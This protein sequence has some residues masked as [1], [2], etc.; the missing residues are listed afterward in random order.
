MRLHAWK[1][2]T[3][4]YAGLLAL[5]LLIPAP[6]GSDL[7]ISEMCDPRYNYA[8]DRFIEIYN[9]G[10]NPV[11]L[12]GWSLQAV[13]NGGI[14]FIWQL[15]GT[16][17][18]GEAL[19]AGDQT[20]TVPFQVDFPDEAW[21]DSNGLWNGKVGDGAKLL[22]PGNVL[23]DCAV[24]EGTAFEN[25]DYVRRPNVT[26]PS[27]TY[28]AAEWISTS[29][30]YPTDGSPGSHVA[31]PPP[32]GPIIAAIFTEPLRPLSGQSVAVFAEVRDTTAA[33]ESVTLAWGTQPGSLPHVIAME[34]L[35]GDTYQTSYPIPGQAP[36]TS[37][38][39]QIEAINTLS[40]SRLSAVL[41]YAVP[42]EL[43]VREIQGE[44]EESPYDNET[45]VT[46]GLVT[47]SFG[48]HFVIQDGTGPW[49]GL[50]VQSSAL[51]GRG[52][53]VTVWGIVDEDS[54]NT[55]L[56][57]A[58]IEESAPGGPLPSP[59]DLTTGAAAT[60][61]YEGVLVKVSDARCMSID[62]ASGVW[63]LYDGSGPLRVGVLG[64]DFEPTLGTRYDV[65]G[66]V[67]FANG[68]FR[69]EPRG[70]EDIVWVGDDFAPI[71][72]GIAVEADTELRVSF[73]EA[74]DPQ[75][76]GTADHYSIPGLVVLAAQHD[77]A[78]PRQVHLTV[79]AMSAGVYTLTVNGV[80]DLFG[81]ATE[82]AEEEFEF[83]DF[84]PPEG[85]YD[86]TAGLAGED[87]QAA[88]YEIIHDHAP[89]S[90][91][92]VWTAF[93]TTDNKPN[94]KVWD[95]YSDIPGGV[96]PYEYTFGVDQGG[97]GGQEGTGYSREHSWP[98]SWFG[99]EVMPMFTDLFAL[100]PTDTHINGMRGVYPYGEVAVPT[101]ISMNGSKLG[102][103]SYPGYTGP[104][105]EPIDA[106]KGDLARTYLY[107]TTR[108][109]SEDAVWPSSPMT[110]GATLR[111]WAVEMLL[112]WHAQDPVSRKEQ[113]RNATIFGFQGNRNPFI[114]C[115][116][117]AELI[118]GDAADVEGDEGPWAAVSAPVLLPAV[119][120]PQPGGVLI[121]F[122]LPAAQEIS[123]EV[124][125]PTG[126]RVAQLSQG[127]V[128]AGVSSILWDGR[129]S[130]GGLAGSGVYFLRLQGHAASATGRALL[131]R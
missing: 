125:D 127:L 62:Q 113:E 95:I 124:C 54:G 4:A 47:A 58:E 77:A 84:S 27:T 92:F 76:A 68:S 98:K 73:S 117:F 59:E 43:T 114:D 88:L 60:E 56:A 14:I 50:W 100:Y 41:S 19:V 51:P 22:A 57:G 64:N 108:Y 79:S 29:A 102:P 85:F 38:Y 122:Q 109:Y 18:P 107:M 44:A 90:Y 31:D 120:S 21:S 121:R 72:W 66:P 105:F 3:T 128:A 35:G 25:A 70:A 86:G 40:E 93:Y 115:P 48:T 94:G 49:E 111:P 69:V 20:T 81:N 131:I 67:A 96:P 130:H 11:D 33:L 63:V 91:A 37:V 13:G 89:V 30:D 71:I 26:Q 45:V 28:S 16:I 6:A 42:Y 5:A 80:E 104:V 118:F 119:P 74:V 103:C 126:R 1:R 99:G 24:V 112:E 9:A 10:V 78:D 61:P 83:V 32:A 52:D 82:D 17:V 97:V 123:I 23:I 53:Q 39:F 116:E 15:S 12:A 55:L 75:T 8:T 2:C 129:L 106:Y 36:G 65:T 7:L 101:W 34:I 46:T 87:L 110:V